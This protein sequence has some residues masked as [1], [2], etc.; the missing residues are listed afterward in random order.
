VIPAS[1]V[2]Q[3]IHTVISEVV[4][5]KPIMGRLTITIDVASTM[6]GPAR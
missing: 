6:L 1:K 3:R 4:L 2:I 5:M